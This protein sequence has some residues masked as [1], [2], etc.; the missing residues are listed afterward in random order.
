MSKEESE[1]PPPSKEEH[2]E[3]WVEGQKILALGRQGFIK[4]GSVGSSFE[5]PGC[6]KFGCSVLRFVLS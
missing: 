3:L 1:S 2:K 6:W 5:G 4:V